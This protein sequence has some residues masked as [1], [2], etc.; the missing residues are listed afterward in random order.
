MFV[1]P[2]SFSCVF[3]SWPVEEG[4]R[5]TIACASCVREQRTFVFACDSCR[6]QKM[7]PSCYK[8]YFH[9][10][11]CVSSNLNIIDTAQTSSRLVTLSRPAGLSLYKFGVGP[12]KLLG[13]GLR[14]SAWKCQRSRLPCTPVCYGQR[15]IFGFLAKLLFLYG[16][17]WAGKNVRNNTIPPLSVARGEN[18]TR[19]GTAPGWCSASEENCTMGNKIWLCGWWRTN[20]R[21]WVSRIEGRRSKS[22]L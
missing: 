8:L 22:K 16:Q 3:S 2:R 11:R 7:H 13:P 19:N 20:T 9:T 4:A 17:K 12:R 10:Q 21:K 1:L 14:P 18:R 6:R 15:Q 5:Y